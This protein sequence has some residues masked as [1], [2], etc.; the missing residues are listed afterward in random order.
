MVVRISDTVDNAIDVS[1]LRKSDC[2]DTWIGPDIFTIP[3]LQ[4]AIYQ[5]TA[6]VYIR[7]LFWNKE[8]LNTMVSS[9]RCHNI[10]DSYEFYAYVSLWIYH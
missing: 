7:A 4:A 10:L 5:T 9:Y 3:I 8:Y 1:V 6:R 2:D